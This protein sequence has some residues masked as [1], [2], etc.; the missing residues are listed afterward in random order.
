MKIAIIS[1]IHG[2]I[3]ALEAVTADIEKWQPDQVVVDGDIVN[4]GP[5]SRQAL[6]WVLTRQKSEDWHLVKG[7]HEDYV[8]ECA[9]PN[10][11]VDE[12]TYQVSQFAYWTYQQVIDYVPVIAKLPEQFSIFAPDGSELRVVHGSMRDNRDGVYPNTTDEELRQQIAPAPRIF[13]T[14]H[15]HR[16]LIREIDGTTVVNIGSV[17]ASFDG[18][19]ALSY[20]RFTWTPENEW[21]VE[22]VRLPYNFAQIEEDYQT[23]GFLTE[24]GPLAQLMLVELRRAGGLVYRWASRYQ[25]AVLAGEISLEDSVRAVLGDEDLRPYLGSPGWSAASVLV[26]EKENDRP[27]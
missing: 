2:N 11:Q 7:N 14:G 21:S 16:P 23:S 24:A 15:T 13:V 3:P 25:E 12:P 10:G 5:L 17:G 8:L 6:E 20:G 18:N 9:T 1:D 19:R 27:G 22:I 4:R 26:A